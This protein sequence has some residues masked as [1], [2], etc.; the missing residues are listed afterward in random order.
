[1]RIGQF[2]IGGT[3]VFL[4]T[5]G[6]AGSSSKPLAVPLRFDQ[7][8]VQGTYGNVNR[9]GLNVA[10]SIGVDAN[11]NTVQFS[12]YQASYNWDCC[13]VTFELRRLALGPVLSNNEY[14]FAFSIANIGTFGN[15]RRQERLF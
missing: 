14:R 3:H 12:G 13:G 9:R 1:Y 7:F 4:Q 11:L 8:R 10:A 6:E 5:P 2:G 15:L